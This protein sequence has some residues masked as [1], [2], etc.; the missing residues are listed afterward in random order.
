MRALLGFMILTMI[1][2]GLLV[3]QE[4]QP[5]ETEQEVFAPFVSRLRTS[6][7]DPEVTLSWQEP[8][9]V[10]GRYQ[11]FRHTEE[12]DTDSFSEAEHIT[13]VESPRTSY[14]D[15]PQRAGTYFYAVLVEDTTGRRYDV[16][17][18]FR[19]TNIRGVEIQN[20]A[21]REDLAAK[22]TGLA[23]SRSRSSAVLRFSA[24]RTGRELIIYRSTKQISG[25]TDLTEATAIDIVPSS[26]TEY[27]DY[28]VP[29]IP[30]FYSIFDTSLAAS[31]GIDFVP[32]ENTTTTPVEIPLGGTPVRLP[33]ARD[34]AFR[35]PL[36]LPYLSAALALDAS[37]EG[38]NDAFGFVNP[39]P[40]DP[41]TVKSVSRLSG[42]DGTEPPVDEVQQAEPF[43]TI[44]DAERIASG[45][46]AQATLRGIVDGSFGRRDWNAAV[47]QLQN[48]LTLPLD[49]TVEARARFYLAQSFYFLNEK[50]EAFLEFLLAREEY[51]TAAQPW[52]EQI[53]AAGI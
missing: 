49:K 48:L 41:D 40:L 51:Y 20:T 45:K 1:A 8:E 16:F 21:T 26:A 3:A 47:D 12:I 5:V 19:N 23:A 7:E 46:G 18:P 22:V 44:L 15:V 37:G 9:D 28:P 11:I 24:D 39:V 31:A 35:R 6:A 10:Q 14:T 50:R 25:T 36:P 33:G 4:E 2:P 13:T 17:V 34:A 29:G 53:L 32:G 52:I 30:Y 38:T 43:P 27:Q 42:R